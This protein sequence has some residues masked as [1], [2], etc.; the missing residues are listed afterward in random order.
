MSE[1]CQ[2]NIF[3]VSAAS[4][5]GKTTLVSRL[6]QNHD[7]IRVSISHT[8]RA[9]REGEQHGKHYYFVDIDQ[10][11]RLV[12]EG[13]FLEHAQVFGN[14]Y[15]TSVAGV[16]N[17]CR[18]GFDVILEIDVQGAQQVRQALPNAISVFILP[19]SLTELEQRL[20]TRQTDN[21]EVIARRLAEAEEEIRNAF[22]FDY[23]VINRD[24]IEAESQLLHIILA[25]RNN[26]RNQTKAIEKVLQNP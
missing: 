7:H 19:P 24:L 11:M 5:T 10:F 20:R 16:E 14:F 15:G 8:T 17:L 18:E 12:G 21:D 3:I 25:Q 9:P 4:G 22:A 6:V 2:G 23:V 1:A 13:A 26:Q